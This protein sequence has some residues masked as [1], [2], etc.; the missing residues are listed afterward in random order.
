MYDDAG[1]LMVSYGDWPDLVWRIE[2]RRDDAGRPVAA[3]WFDDGPDFSEHDC[4]AWSWDAAG[5]LM[6]H[7]F[8]A[9]C[10]GSVDWSESAESAYDDAGRLVE[11]TWEGCAAAEMGDSLLSGRG[12]RTL[13]YDNEDRVCRTTS[14]VDEIC[15]GT[16]DPQVTEYRRYDPDAVIVMTDRDGE[17]S[18]DAVAVTRDDPS[19]GTILT[20][21]DPEG[22]SREVSDAAGTVLLHAD[23]S[24]CDGLAVGRS[25]RSLDPEGRMRRTETDADG[26]GV[27]ESVSTRSYD[28]RGNLIEENEPWRTT[29]HDY[30]CWR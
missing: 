2:Y 10:N 8:D 15:G 16:P 22:C 1:H 23:D 13:T 26:D 17:G 4:E 28:D 25:V 27:A 5:R 3:E 30:A 12:E 14:V 9:G 6:A 11:E 21:R 7:T 29:R 24:L 18:I 20:T 19:G